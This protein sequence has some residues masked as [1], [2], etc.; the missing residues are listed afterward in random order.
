MST[1]DPEDRYY[2]AKL[3]SLR[4]DALPNTR[5]LAAKWAETVGTILGLLGG[6]VVI[7]SKDDVAG[8]ATGAKL[9]AFALLALGLAAGLASLLLAASAAQGEFA[10]VSPGTR[11]KK[12]FEDEVGSARRKLSFSRWA[13]VASVVCLLA[14]LATSW[15]APGEESSDSSTLVL[16]R[17]EAYCGTLVGHAGG[18]LTLELSSGGQ[19]SVPLRR[20]TSVVAG[21][22][23]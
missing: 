20:V 16:T 13:V 4:R 23:C 17:A 22:T 8:L 3:A 5:A 9:L 21:A 18:S 10:T 15:Y 11:A 6:S 12:V 14:A 1:V 7:V 2:E 19:I